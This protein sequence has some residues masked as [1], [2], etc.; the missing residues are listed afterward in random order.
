MS[1]LALVLLITAAAG[2][3]EVNLAASAASV[4]EGG[5]VVLTATRSSSIGALDVPV[6]LTGTPPAGVSLA[7]AQF[8]FAAGA[9][10]A[11]VALQTTDD[12]DANGLRQATAQLTLVAGVTSTVPAVTVGIRDD[13]V[14]VAVLAIDVAAA[15]AVAP[16]DGGELDIVIGGPART[17]PLWVQFE[18][19][20]TARFEAAGTDDYTLTYQVGAG[21]A[22]PITSLSGVEVVN[23]LVPPGESSIA[24]VLTGVADATVEGGETCEIRLPTSS[25]AYTV[26]GVDRAAITIADD[27]NR[28]LELTGTP[29]FESGSDG[30]ITIGFLSTF[31]NNRVI[32]VPYAI[33]GAPNDGSHFTA[34]SGIAT[35]AANQTTITIPIHAL[36]DTSKDDHNL[37]FTLLPSADYILPGTP[38]VTVPLVDVAGGA[39]IAGP[40]DGVIESAVTSGLDFTVTVARLPAFSTPGADLSVPFRLTGTTAGPGEYSV[41]G[42][43]VSWDGSSGTIVI[44]S[45]SDTGTI[46]ITPIDDATADGDKTVR[47]ALESGQSVIIPGGSAATGTILDDEPVVSLVRSGAATASEGGAGV[48]FTVSYPGVPAATARNQAVTARFAVTGTASVADRTITGPGV[49]LDADSLG[50]TVSIPANALETTIVVTAAADALAEPAEPVILTLS[51]PA[52]GSPYRLG[53]AVSAAVDLVDALSTPTVAISALADAIEGRTVTCF[54]VT[55]T[56]ATT[57]ALTVQL[58]APGGVATAADYAALPT[59]LSIPIGA[60]HADLAVTAIADGPDSGDTI[61]LTITAD[62]AYQLGTDSATISIVDGFADNQLA[63]ASEPDDLLPLTGDGWTSVCRLV[64]PPGMTA[65]RTRA[66]LAAVAGGGAPPAW[67]SVSRTSPAGATGIAVFTLT[68]SPPVGTSAGRVPV[69]LLLEADIDNDGA[70]EAPIPQDLLLWVLTSGGGG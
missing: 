67:L 44:A 70:F 26:A 14:T 55:R 60:D 68:G 18:I 51:A 63:I 3:V 22:Q 66:S 32:Q 54:R 4:T 65:G 21:A 40:A 7:A 56:G 50:G 1:R 6:A 38:S 39:S 23:V 62:A 15:E 49:V 13:D 61:D 2:A 12:P 46:T 57:A 59:S 64:L 20:G 42:T 25:L 8:S 31:A 27:D 11:T 16:V 34:L 37:T 35:L 53:T 41:G 29:A 47:V 52:P 58:A 30:A 36:P 48:A 28:I 9:T 24:L 43:G 19:H 69:R 5:A 45:G 10:T 17:D 33:S